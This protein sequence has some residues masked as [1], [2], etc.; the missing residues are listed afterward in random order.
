MVNSFKAL[1]VGTAKV[2]GSPG[3]R[4]WAEIKRWDPRLH[5]TQAQQQKVGVPETQMISDDLRYSQ[6]LF[7]VRAV[8]MI[9][10]ARLGACFHL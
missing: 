3:S 4:E 7:E 9:F 1:H 8:S 10:A 6:F 5:M 2:T